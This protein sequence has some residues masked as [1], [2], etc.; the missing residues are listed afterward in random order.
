MKTNFLQ[1]KSSREQFHLIR[2][3]A[4]LTYKVA[5]SDRL[6]EVPVSLIKQI[7]HSLKNFRPANLYYVWKL[8]SLSPLWDQNPGMGK[9]R[10]E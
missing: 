6:S 8:Q 1:A 2:H 10:T 3:S 7:F 4:A 5:Q 9:T